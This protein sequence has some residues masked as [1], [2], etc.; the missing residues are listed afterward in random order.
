M[1]IPQMNPKEIY[2][3]FLSRIEKTNML[4][5]LLDENSSIELSNSLYFKYYFDISTAI[6]AIIRGIVA[7]ESKKHPY[8]K[9]VTQADSDSK[10]YFIKYE[11]LKALIISVENLYQDP[12]E[13]DFKT[14]IC[15]KV[16]ILKDY[17]LTKKF[18]NNGA[19]K[20]DYESIR[21]TRNILAHGLTGIYSVDYSNTQLESF[22]FVCYLLFN[23]Y[24][25]IYNLD[26]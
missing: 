16:D 4:F 22:L 23:Y 25:K 2:N 5:Q 26:N 1:S 17:R 9:Y 15:E 21:K 20:N 8:I 7:E 19:F 11:E 14:K 13:E 12:N 6:E 24:E 18:V 10:A 3:G